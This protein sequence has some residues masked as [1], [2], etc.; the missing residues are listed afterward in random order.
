MENTKM[1]YR[2]IALLALLLFTGFSPGRL[3]ATVD[4]ALSGTVLDDQ[5][6]AVPNAKVTI[7]GNGTEKDLISSTTGT[8]Q[9]FPLTIGDY[10]VS[11]QAEGFNLYRGTVA[12]SGNSSSLEVKL[13]P[14]GEIQMTV[15]AKRHLV[16]PASNSSRD[17]NSDDIA[18]LPEGATTSLPKLLYTT[19][20]GFVEGDFGQVF[21]RGNHANLQYQID[22]I[23]LPDSVG[24]SFGEAF[25][26]VNIDHM[27]ILTGGLAPEFGTR[28]AGVVN[29]VTKSGSTEPGGE[30]GLDYGSYNQTTTYANYGGSDTSGALHYFLSANAFSTDRGL[31]TPAPADINNDQNGGSEQAIHDKSYGSDGFLKLDYVADNLNKLVLVAFSENKFYQIPDY[32]SSFDPGGSN[33]AYLQGLKDTYGNGPF[34]YVPS[35]TNDTQS[36]ANKYV[37]FAWKHTFDE[38][39]FIQIAPYWK[40]SNL[41]FTNDPSSDF[42]AAQDDALAGLLGNITES[43]FSEN[44]TSDNYGA[45]VDYTWHADSN[46]LIK[47]GGQVLLT[48]SSGPVSVMEVANSGSGPSTTASSDDATD[49]GYQE[50]IYV[51]DELTLA[52]WLVVNGGIRFDATQFV[53]PDTTST[54]SN[55]G[56]RVGISLLPTESTKFHVFYGKLFMPAPAEDLRDTFVNL[57]QG[58]QLAPYDIKA[59]KDDYFEAGLAQQAGEQLFTL[60]TYYKFATNMLDETQLLNTAIAQPYNFATGYA[61]GVEFSMRGK[62]DKDWS[63]FAN[64]SYEIAE[65]QGISGGLFAFPAGTNFEPG[66]YQFLDHCQIHTANGGLTYNPGDVWITAEGLFGGGLSTGPNNSLR[67]PSHFTADLTLGYAFKKDSGLAGMKASLDVL[68][69]FDNPYVIFIDNGYNGNHYENGREF[70]FHLVKEI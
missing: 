14:A 65:G 15:K 4:G 56:P 51:Q 49:T 32:D 68:N 9:V 27:E 40:E 30:I 61:Y 25:T 16:T 54:D 67:L 1:T 66:V 34:N 12:V 52:K 7:T 42:A 24:G 57:G 13:S 18:Q 39:S 64:Y 3:F 19:T 59:E 43:S 70:I 29:I 21:T 10:Q 55:W 35:T 33:F 31:D 38:N 45:Q 5:G 26:P 47:A 44:R 63:E 69:V 46:N 2:F 50:G 23:Q 20:A 36:E 17:L 8:F 22:G 48:Q 41:T 60:N 6:V 58:N 62:I 28:M 53:F 11:V 37:E